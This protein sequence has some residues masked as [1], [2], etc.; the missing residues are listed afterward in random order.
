MKNVTLSADEV[1]IEKARLK[2]LEEKT[3]LNAKFREWLKRYVSGVDGAEGY[4]ALMR[5]LG[6]VEA[7]GTFDREKRNER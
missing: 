1:L 7:G 3:T 5:D 6:T 2:A 4:M